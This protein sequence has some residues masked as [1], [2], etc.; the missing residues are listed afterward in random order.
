MIK[1]A[2]VD[3]N[4]FL[5]QTI[6]EKLHLFNDIECKC[7]AENG[8][9]LLAKL[10]L[11][12]NL[13]LILM[14]IEMPLMNGI[15][16]TVE[17]KRLY[18]H[19]KV[20]MLTVFDN[21]ETIFNAIKAGADGYLLKETNPD[22]LHKAIVDTLS[23]GA[24]MTPSIALKTLRMVRQPEHFELRPPQED[25]KLTERELSVLEQLATGIKYERIA[26]NLFVSTG[27]IRKHIENIYTK[28]QVHNKLEAIQKARKN[29][30]I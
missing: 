23:G 7:V 27:T 28:L 16:T 11:N 4:S 6:V 26:S 9:E 20:I 3:D 5:R 17:I 24:S 14:D 2:L 12:T 21:D 13:E 8:K 15:Q 30:I 18:P 22:E 1:V 19:L 29:K 25:L 10:A